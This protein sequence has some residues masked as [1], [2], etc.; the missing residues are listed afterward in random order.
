MPGLGSG[1]ACKIPGKLFRRSIKASP[2]GRPKTRLSQLFLV[3]FAH[4]P[5]EKASYRKPCRARLTRPANA[6]SSKRHP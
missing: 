3:R 4:L 6:F 2:C 1:L 5:G